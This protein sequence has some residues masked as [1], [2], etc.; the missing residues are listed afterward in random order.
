MAGT[1]SIDILADKANHVTYVGFFLN[2]VLLIFKFAA[3]VIGHSAAMIADAVHSLS[4]FATDIV[5]LVSFRVIRKPAD[6]GHDYGHGKCE[7]LATAII[8]VALFFV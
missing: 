5:V 4:D 1:N 2:L 6:R 7:T 3:G 8:G